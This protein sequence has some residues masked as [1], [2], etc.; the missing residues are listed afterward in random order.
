[1]EQAGGPERAS[2]IPVDG[3]PVAGGAAHAAGVGVWKAHSAVVFYSISAARAIP[4]MAGWVS[5][6]AS[7]VN[8]RSD[9]GR[10]P[11]AELHGRTARIPRLALGLDESHPLKR[12]HQAVANVTRK[13]ALDLLPPLV[14][15]RFAHARR[16][17][18][19]VVAT[20]DGL[21]GSTDG[22]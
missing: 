9:T 11:G 12:P 2:A 4:R 20:L 16:R 14:R 1:M 18:P 13:R 10:D 7:C 6:T 8:A 3:A 22:P 21:S 15:L 17:R 19:A 5:W